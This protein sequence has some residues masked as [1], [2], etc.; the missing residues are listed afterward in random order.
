MKVLYNGVD[1]TNYVEIKKCIHEEYHEFHS[2][3]LTIDMR[4]LDE[5]W[6]KW[7]PKIDDTIKVIQGVTNTGT[8]YI[9]SLEPMCGSYRINAQSTKADVEELH[10]KE[11]GII[12]F[13]QILQEIANRH[14]LVLRTYE[15]AD[16]RYKKLSQKN[17]NDLD[18]LSDLCKLEGY[19]YLI[20]DNQLVCY[21]KTYLEQ[22]DAIQVEITK[23]NQYRLFRK[24]TFGGLK[25]ISGTNE[26]I[27]QVGNG[28]L[29]DVSIAL[30]N[31]SKAEQERFA[32][33]LFYHKTKE[34]ESGYFYT[35]QINESLCAGNTIQLNISAASSFSNKCV[36]SQVRNDYFNNRS[37]VFF[38]VL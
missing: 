15:I 6:D 35:N 13:L 30:E 20:F 37:K 16:T 28:Y 22:R 32:K 19:H 29:V 3:M 27:H 25:L 11:W 2:D 21:S 9:K 33:N 5:K 12:S 36:I 14:N 18:F 24:K 31:L 8:M 17:Q 4:D 1:I 10:N 38:Y 26:Y 34:S 23:D 7:N